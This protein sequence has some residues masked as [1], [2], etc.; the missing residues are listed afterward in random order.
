MSQPNDT[1]ACCVWQYGKCSQTPASLIVTGNNNTSSND[2]FT[3]PA[4]SSGAVSFYLQL[5]GINTGQTGS[6]DF[7]RPPLPTLQTVCS[8]AH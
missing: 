1:T 8:T 5:N 6:C 7:V 3:V 4:M 2:Y